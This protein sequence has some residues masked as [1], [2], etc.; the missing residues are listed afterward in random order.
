MSIV[1]ILQVNARWAMTF[2]WWPLFINK[3]CN[4]DY[5]IVFDPLSS[6][7]IIEDMTSIMTISNLNM[8]PEKVF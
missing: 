2:F 5:P 7:S 8:M 3:E 6:N 1:V 4:D